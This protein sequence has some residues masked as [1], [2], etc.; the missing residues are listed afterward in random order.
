MVTSPGLTGQSRPGVAMML[1]IQLTINRFAICGKMLHKL[2]F[3]PTLCSM[4]QQLAAAY[5][6]H[7]TPLA[8]LI[9]A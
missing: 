2:K 1:H 8:S 9:V 3:L 5:N 6:T 4:L 7:E